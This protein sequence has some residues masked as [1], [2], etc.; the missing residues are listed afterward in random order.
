[1]FMRKFAKLSAFILLGIGTLGLLINEFVLDWGQITTLTFAVMNVVG[2]A[3]LVFT[4]LG[5][6]GKYQE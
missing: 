5:G 3:T 2:L 4:H 1:M 6:K